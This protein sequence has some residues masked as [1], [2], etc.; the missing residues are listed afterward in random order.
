[1]AAVRGES[2]HRDLFSLRSDDQINGGGADVDILDL[3]AGLGRDYAGVNLNYSGPENGNVEFLDADG[4]VIS[5]LEF[6]EIEKVVVCFT[7]GTTILTPNGERPVEELS[8]G[9]KVHTRDNGMQEIRW[10]G[11]KILGHAD[12]VHDPKLAPVL[13][14]KGALGSGLPERDMMVSPNHRL[15]VTS[16]RAQLYFE[17]RE[18]LVAA[19]HLVGLP[20]FARVAVPQTSY[21]HFMCDHHEVVQSNGIWTESFQPGDYTLN[22]ID[23]DQRH[24]LNKLFPG[25]KTAIGQGAYNSARRA[26]RRHEAELLIAS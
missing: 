3:S 1:M 8:V 13:I 2:N 5:R 21:I 25:L 23:V 24:E 22:A 16:S 26:L 11:T 6:S 17:E 7:P 4:G 12:L 20:G 14:R 18:V 10:I 19:K 9:D 15:L